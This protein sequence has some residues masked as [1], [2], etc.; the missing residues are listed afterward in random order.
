[1]SLD[2]SS[3]RPLAVVRPGHPSAADLALANALDAVHAEVIAMPSA[4]RLPTYIPELSR[5]PLDRF[6]MHVVTCEGFSHGVGHDAEAFS[7][8]SIS[9]VFSLAM[10]FAIEGERIWERIGVEPTG[11]S[12]NSVA[13]LEQ[14]DGMP[15][16]PF[17]NAGALVIADILLTHLH[18]PEESLL[19][20]VR[21]VSGNAA[22]VSDASMAASEAG[23]GFMNA[24]L[25]NV[26][27]HHGNLRNSIERV[28]RLYYF[29][30]ALRMSCADLA[31]AFTHFADH[32]VPFQ[33]GG[34]ELTRSQVKRINALMMTCGFYDESGDFCYRVGLPGK[35]GVGGGI[36]ALNPGGFAVAVWS[37]GLNAKGNSLRGMR[38]LELLT[39]LTKRSVF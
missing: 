6:G 8:Q 25:A 9:K 10:A 16:N 13:L 27:K 33:F 39:T 3:A 38:A 12:F 29:Q 37:P 14:L 35:S 11:A 31:A 26:L 7:V 4:G 34:T 28:L 24:A 5:V 21:T 32:R 18:E 15:R 1:M 17:V 20:F 36:A 23:A 19:R 22:L 30:C 2:A